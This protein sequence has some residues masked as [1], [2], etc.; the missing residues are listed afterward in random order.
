[1]RVFSKGFFSRDPIN[2][3]CLQLT[4]AHC[5]HS[6]KP[7]WGPLYQPHPSSSDICLQIGFSHKHCYL[8]KLTS[9]GIPTIRIRKRS[10]WA[11]LSTKYDCRALRETLKIAT[12]T[13]AIHRVFFFTKFMRELLCS[14]SKKAIKCIK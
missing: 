14:V 13:S 8:L 4:S 2:H 1:M 6:S 12:R 11:F 9:V 10:F 3:S 7:I 5:A